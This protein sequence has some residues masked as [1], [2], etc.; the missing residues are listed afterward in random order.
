MS[1][2][3]VG[4]TC[5][6]RDFPSRRAM[7]PLAAGPSPSSAIARRYAR[8]A[9]VARFHR[10][11]P[12]LDL[13]DDPVSSSGPP[14]EI[15]EEHGLTDTAKAGEHQALR[16]AAGGGPGEKGLELR[17]VGVTSGKLGR[18]NAGTR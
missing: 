15:V 1:F 9:G 18:R 6:T 7:S 17:D 16:G 5:W 10:L 12:G 11:R 8:S 2:A 3:R 13:G 4:P 14:S